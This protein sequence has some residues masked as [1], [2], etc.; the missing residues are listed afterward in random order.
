MQYE[1]DPPKAVLN[2]RKHG[3]SFDEA[4]TVFLDQLAVSGTDPDHS[5]V[6]SR[7]ITLPLK[8]R[9]SENCLLCPT[10]IVQAAFASSVRVASLALRGI[11]MKKAEHEMRA[12]YKRSDFANLER[13]KFLKEASKGTSVALIEPNLAK[14]F[15]TSEAVNEALRGLLALADETARITGRSKGAARKRVAV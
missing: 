10:L 8:C 3:V 7:Y 14:A 1:W 12:E 13:G 2:L 15:P 4:A 6:E 11:C 9:V 5:L